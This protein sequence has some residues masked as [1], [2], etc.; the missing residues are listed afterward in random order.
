MLATLV[1]IINQL[2]HEP[3]AGL[4]NGIL[5]GVKATLSKDLTDALVASGT[6]HIIALSG[7]NISI[8]VT[9]VNSTLL[10]LVRR[11]IANIITIGLICGFVGVVG[12]TPS[13]LR[14][15]LM[16]VL[17]LLAVNFGRQIW[18]IYSWMLAVAIMLLLNP[19]WIAD[20]SFQLSV[21]AT[22]GIILFGTRDA[23][24]Q[25][26][27]YFLAPLRTGLDHVSAFFPRLSSMVE[28]VS[29]CGKRSS[30][31]LLPLVRI[32][33]DDLRVTLAA[34]VFTVP[35]ILFQFQ[36][37]S[38]VSPLS[39][40][41]IGWLIAPI[42]VLGFAAIAGA[43]VYWPLGQLIAWCT[44]VL[45]TFVVRIIEWTASLPFASISF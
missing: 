14:A 32:V 26:N 45:L 20:L 42:M 9:L 7:M 17:S 30:K 22:L 43:C 11:P 3:Q 25:G 41:L 19:P 18:P 44:W 38:L 10:Y 21:M 13:V 8:L 16:G 4:L 36:R 24:A 31:I 23:H 12:I 2:F 37:I 27:E 29:E 35:I 33:N 39:N 6:L 40:I 28:F 34:Q 5:F 1:S 15:A